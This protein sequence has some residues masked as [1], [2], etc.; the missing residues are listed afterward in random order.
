M[1]LPRRDSKASFVTP[2]AWRKPGISKTQA[3]RISLAQAA[4]EESLQKVDMN[5]GGISMAGST[6]I[7]TAVLYS[8]MATFDLLANQTQYKDQLKAL[9][10]KAATTLTSNFSNPDVSYLHR[11]SSLIARI[12]RT[13][14]YAAASAYAAYKDSAFLVWA[15][16]NW[17]FGLDFTIS[18]QQ[19]DGTKP[20]RKNFTLEA[21]CQGITM[22]GGSYSVVDINSR[23]V[24]TLSTGG[25][26]VNSAL[27]AESIGDNATYL[28]AAQASAH[29]IHAHL[30]SI[31]HIVQDSI[32]ALSSDKCAITD[33]TIFAYNQGLAAEGLAI[34]TSLDTSSSENQDLLYSIISTGTNNTDWHTPAGIISI[35]EHLWTSGVGSDRLIRGVIAAYNRNLDN[36]TLRSYLGSYIGV[37]YNA[38]LDLATAGNNVYNGIWHGD[39]SGHPLPATYTTDGQS[40]A[41]S[42]LLAGISIQNDTVSTVANGDPASGSPATPESATRHKSPAGAIAGGIIGGLL[43]MTLLIGGVL[44][45]QRRKGQPTST[46]IIN[47][48]DL[49]SAA[50]PPGRKKQK[51]LLRLPP[52]RLVEIFLEKHLPQPEPDHQPL[53]FSQSDDSNDIVE[54]HIQIPVMLQSDPHHWAVESPPGYQTAILSATVNFNGINDNPTSH[55]CSL[56]RSSTPY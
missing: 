28:T 54:E 43:F 56:N 49:E 21:E 11:I 32:S 33:S 2:S 45:L 3:E 17:Q 27:L 9:F 38:V 51:Q 41:I 23:D 19:I 53:S 1:P 39:S 31:E 47:E 30:T 5:T 55:N 4:I 40:L 36:K 25:L 13:Y 35:P 8:Q 15:Q 52:P 14:G 37:Q 20:N 16:D 7:N 24:N 6:I 18:Q 50:S 46:H 22:A 48:Y 12:C 26:L 34:L 42:V 44:F 10:V 29:F